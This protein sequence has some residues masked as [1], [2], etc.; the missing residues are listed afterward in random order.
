MG[1]RLTP[2]WFFLGFLICAGAAARG[3]QAQ[4]AFN[5]RGRPA[6]AAP[7]AEYTET[8]KRKWGVIP[9]STS[10]SAVF[11]FRTASGGTVSATRG[12]S[13]AML[14][15]MRAGQPVEIE[16]LP[17]NP[18]SFRFRGENLATGG[19]Q[20]LGAYFAVLAGWLFWRRRR[21]AGATDAAQAA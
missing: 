8:T 10:Y 3:R 21:L 18:Q 11:T 4:K 16:Y 12:F 1:S 2:L 6:V 20:L 5:D 9:I 7:P 19:Y 15:Q 14:A 17:A 13:K